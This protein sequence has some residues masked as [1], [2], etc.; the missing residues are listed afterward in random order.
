VELT[1]PTLVFLLITLGLVGVGIEAL[2]PGGVVPGVV[3]VIAL[4]LGVI[5]VVDIGATAAGLGLLILAIA[6]FIAAVALK[7][8]RPLSVLGVISLVASGVWM[9]DRDTDPTSIPAVVIG[10]IVLGTFLLFVIERSSAVKASPV[11]YGPEE[12]VGMTGDVRQTLSPRGQV[13]IDGA[14]W[15]AESSDPAVR[16][17]YGERIRV[18]ALNGLTLTVSRVGGSPETVSTTN[19]QG[20]DQ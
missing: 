4:V 14:L 10:S 9:F 18:D 2:T 6:F 7:L 1:D 19:E 11:R 3:G 15:Q 8:F 12:L 17:D 16:I 5:G 20:A 13:F